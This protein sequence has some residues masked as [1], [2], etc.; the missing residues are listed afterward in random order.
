MGMKRLWWLKWVYAGV[1]TA[2]VITVAVLLAMPKTPLPK[3]IQRKAASTLLMPQS[4]DVVIQRDTAKFDSSLRLL[5]F[6]VVAYGTQAVISEQP[7][8]ESFVDIPQVYD[9]VVEQMQEY[10]KFEV[11]VGTVHLTRPVDLKG[12]QAAVL[13]TKGTLMFVKP[14]HD[15]S[16]ADW[17]RFFN[18]VAVVK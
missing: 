11:D 10:T 8:P 12:K 9:K 15:L 6:S 5:S 1:V 4:R 7:T 13:N 17:R 16:E 18:S 14:D 3:E 2:G